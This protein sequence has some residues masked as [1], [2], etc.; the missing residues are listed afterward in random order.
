MSSMTWLS[1]PRSSTECC[2]H[3]AN[4]ERQK[5]SRKCPLE[6]SPML[7]SWRQRN[8]S[9]HR[10]KRCP[11]L[12]SRTTLRFE[13]QFHSTLYIWFLVLCIH[14]HQ[15]RSAISGEHGTHTHPTQLV[16]LCRSCVKKSKRG[17]TDLSFPW[18]FSTRLSTLR[19]T[20]TTRATNNPQGT[21]PHRWR[22]HTRHRRQIWRWRLCRPTI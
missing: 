13:I 18:S 1:P 22:L 20:I 19:T 12:A 4:N 15:P 7:V 2:K 14:A 16:M 21:N 17:R 9:H 5:A 6:T 10:H 3:F 8:L 11:A